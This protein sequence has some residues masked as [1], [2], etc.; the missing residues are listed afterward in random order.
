MTSN[1]A[2]A[3]PRVAKTLRAHFPAE[4]VSEAPVVPASEDF[5]LFGSE[6]GVPSVFWVVGGTDPAVFARLKAEGRLNE[7]P[8]NHSSHL[9][10]VIHP[11]L[12]TGIETLVVAPQARLAA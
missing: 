2:D 10:P 1:D 11:T 12:E 7:L 3:T 9:L 4:R 8:I 5:G 6:W